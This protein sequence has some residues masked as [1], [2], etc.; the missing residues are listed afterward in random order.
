[1]AGRCVGVW[2]SST[3]NIV[4]L[5]ALIVAAQSGG[6][7]GSCCCGSGG[8]CDCD[9]TA[10]LCCLEALDISCMMPVFCCICGW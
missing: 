4:K 3:V 7:G 2:I 5:S 1:M 8:G 6:G 9:T 10:A